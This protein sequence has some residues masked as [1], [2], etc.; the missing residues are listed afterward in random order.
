[1]N[2]LVSTTIS[3]DLTP[4]VFNNVR[5]V[6]LNDIDIAHSK[7]S[8]TA[9]RCFSRNREHFIKDV[10]YIILTKDN[11]MGQNDTLGIS[12]IPNRGIVLLT[13]SGYLMIAKSFTD[14]LSWEVQRDLVNN[15]FKAKEVANNISNPVLPVKTK[16]SETAEPDI[17]KI[18]KKYLATREEF[19]QRY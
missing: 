5:V 8:G 13:E 4:R 11:Q 16:W 3:V 1:M 19:F 6:T 17:Q 9:R 10:D 7:K 18:M 2:E 15:Y 14:D 12:I